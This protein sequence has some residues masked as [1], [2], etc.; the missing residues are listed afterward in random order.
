[1][2]KRMNFATGTGVALGQMWLGYNQYFI[3]KLRP[4]MQSL[5]E[6]VSYNY[7]LCPLEPGFLPGWINESCRAVWP[8]LS[9][10]PLSP[11]FV[12]D[13]QYQDVMAQVMPRENFCHTEG[14]NNILVFIISHLKKIL[15]IPQ[16]DFNLSIPDLSLLWLL[17]HYSETFL[18]FF[19]CLIR[20]FFCLRKCVTTRGH[21]KTKT[22][23][24][25]SKSLFQC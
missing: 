19:F 5:P 18:S 21:G 20:S 16:E 4:L 12:A 7:I 13:V 11:C 2:E 22:Y 25:E 1:M 24:I 6:K 23:L 9:Q 10:Q 15:L 14:K 3:W 17:I 8:H